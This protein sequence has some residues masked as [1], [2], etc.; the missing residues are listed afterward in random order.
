MANP[1]VFNAGDLKN[2]QGFMTGIFPFIV[3]P[4]MGT[5]ILAAFMLVTVAGHW[6]AYEQKIA[7]IGFVIAWGITMVSMMFGFLHL[8]KRPVEVTA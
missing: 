3:M 1:L 2:L 7:F 5:V 6:S 4:M 8:R